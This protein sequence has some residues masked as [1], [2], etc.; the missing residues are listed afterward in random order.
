MIND[1][2]DGAFSQPSATQQTPINQAFGRLDN[3]ISR[4][5]ASL[6]IHSRRLTPVLAEPGPQQA[7]NSPDDFRF[8]GTTANI[9]TQ[10]DQQ[11]IRVNEFA[12]QIED[13]TKRLLL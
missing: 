4:L 7:N 5:R 13:L 6:D 9:I 10:I 11:T 3:T 2:M 12:A 8:V 1:E